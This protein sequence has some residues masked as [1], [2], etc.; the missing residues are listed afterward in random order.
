MRKT[1]QKGEGNRNPNSDVWESHAKSETLA[2]GGCQYDPLRLDV[3]VRRIEEALLRSRYSDRFE[4]VTKLAIRAIDLRRALLDHR[5]QIVHFSGHGT[6]DQGLVLENDAGEMQLVSTEALGRLFSIFESGA[7][8]C[9]LLNACYSEIQATAI[10]QSVDCVI[11]MNQPIG[12][13]AAVQFAEG[14]Y[15]ALGAGSLYD[16]AFRIGCSA[17]DLD[18]S[19]EY[20]KPVLKYRKRPSALSAAQ[21]MTDSAE[22]KEIIPPMEKPKPAQSQSIG[23]ISF[24]GNNPSNV[25][26][27]SQGDVNINPS[28]TQTQ[29]TNPDLQAALEAIANLK[30]AV[31]ANDQLDEMDKEM[32]AIPMKKLEAELQKPQPDRGAVDKAIAMIRKALDGV[33][34]LESVVTR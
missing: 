32:A 17:I 18:G 3:E 20:E 19:S 13:K 34:T 8:E 7:T 4:L 2:M 6:G 11:G 21:L 22:S 26:M 10:H 1:S 16:E 30:Q 9:V 31:A 5:P 27:Q 14:F 25:L 33:M 12:D 23:N 29:V 28:R 15:D 24:S